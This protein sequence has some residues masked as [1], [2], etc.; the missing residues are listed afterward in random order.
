MGALA[1]ISM[2]MEIIG[3]SGLTPEKAR[4]WLLFL[5]AVGKRADATE[6]DL[7]QAVETIKAGVAAG[8]GPTDD[9][10]AAHEVSIAASSAKFSTWRAANQ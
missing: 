5:A 10:W 4:E 9:E 6:K 7:E 8:R 2:G 1:L 3:M